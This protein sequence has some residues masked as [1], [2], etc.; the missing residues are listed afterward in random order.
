MKRLASMAAALVLFFA[1]FGAA[2]AGEITVKVSHS[3]LKPA[4][5]S[6]KTGDT[7]TFVNMVTMPGGHTLTADD[8][9][10]KSEP[11][12]KKGASWSHTFDNPGSHPYRILQHPKVTGV[13]T[14][15]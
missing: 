15:K 1:L 14:V 12:V 7:V 6:V 9:A 2:S 13:I 8:K 3:S 11:L 4:Q 5:V 10:F